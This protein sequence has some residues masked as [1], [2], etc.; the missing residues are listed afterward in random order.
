METS[1]R[2]F[3]GLLGIGTVGAVMPKAFAQTSKP[4]STGLYIPRNAPSAN[5]PNP[6]LNI[7]PIS[8]MDIDGSDIAGF[9]E[10]LKAVAKIARRVR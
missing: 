4:I 7:R 1:R 9:D 3:L 8:G 5:D 10:L 6:L 2:S